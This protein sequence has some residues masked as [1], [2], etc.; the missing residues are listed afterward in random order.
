MVFGYFAFLKA[1]DSKLAQ[2][3]S[4]ISH[5]PSTL[6]TSVD[7]TEKEIINAPAS[8]IIRRVQETKTWTTQQV[9]TAFSKQALNA[10]RETNCLTEILIS[11]AITH[12]VELDTE[13]RRTNKAVGPLHGVP[14]S[15]K[16][17]FNIH[18][19]DSSIGYSRWVGRQAVKDSVIVTLLKKAGA[20]LYVKTNVPQTLL[21]F[22]S[23]NPVG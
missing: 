1:R 22:E 8:E 7:A 21:S 16:D 11:K 15:L 23:W 2:R 9:V 19:I 3:N 12:A 17:S 6:H 13:L 14:V 4:S 18:G 20:T 5:L 10:H